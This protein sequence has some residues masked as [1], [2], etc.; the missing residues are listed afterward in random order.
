M[1][2]HTERKHNIGTELVFFSW[3]GKGVDGGKKDPNLDLQS[4][5]LFGGEEKIEIHS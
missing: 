3:V 1:D 4:R 2:S 5:Y